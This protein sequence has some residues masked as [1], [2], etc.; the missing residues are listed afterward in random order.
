MFTEER[1][2]KVV[3]WTI[4][5]GLPLMV[6]MIPTNIFFTPQIRLFLVVT[7][8]AI[9]LF[10]FEIIVQAIPAI[11]L[12]LAYILLGIAPVSAVL[13]P[14]SSSVVWAFLGGLVLLNVVLRNGL[15]DRVAYW[16]IIKT[17]GSYKGILWGL[18]LVGFVF[19]LVIPGAHVPIMLAILTYGV[20]HA[21]QLGKSKESAGIMLMGA[22]AALLPGLAIDAQSVSVLIGVAGD[23]SF[24]EYIRHNIPVVFWCILITF[25]ISIMFK[26]TKKI[27]GKDDFEA[28][29]IKLGKMTV[30]EKKTVVVICLL[31]IFLFTGNDFL[32]NI[33][34]GWGFAIFPLLLFL[35]GINVGIVEDVKKV[36][37][38][39]LLIVAAC[40]SIGSV[41]Y[42]MG[43]SELMTDL[44]MIIMP[45]LASMSTNFLLMFVYILCFL[46]NFLLT[47]L[48]VISAMAIPLAAIRSIVGFDFS[49]INY[50]VIQ[51][52]DQIILPYESAA[53]LIFFSFGLIKFTDFVKFMSLK[54]VLNFIFVFLIMVPYWQFIGLM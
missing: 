11:A 1:A 54:T 10:S 31:F 21:L 49:A 20:C 37:L 36:N 35:P 7:L 32:H 47:P 12:P 22:C 19:A 40:L 53:Y 51:A 41:A 17:G 30:D 39:F 4:S 9:L 2:K 14:W 45:I 29:Y 6:L 28:R 50:V 34:L 48:D 24:F 44:A 25:V 27:A 38:S 23:L 33:E 16:Y 8:C 3:M 46:L 26:S 42:A 5:I 13:E 52:V 15:L 18:L 43:L